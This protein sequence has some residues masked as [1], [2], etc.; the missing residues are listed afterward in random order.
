LS[1]GDA[2]GGRFL[3]IPRLNKYVFF[4]TQVIELKL[5]VSVFDLP[6]I[7]T[8]SMEPIKVYIKPGPSTTGIKIKDLLI[9]SKGNITII[10]IE[11]QES[12]NCQ[13]MHCGYNKASKKIT[14]TKIYE[15]C[16]NVKTG[17][18]ALDNYYLLV[19]GAKTSNSY[20][21][22]AF[23]L[24]KLDKDGKFVNKSVISISAEN[25]LRYNSGL[26]YGSNITSKEITFSISKDGTV[27]AFLLKLP[28]T[29]DWIPYGVG[30]NYYYKSF[31]WIAFNTATLASKTTTLGRYMTSRR[32]NLEPEYVI[33]G[34]SS[35]SLLTYD[36]QKNASSGLSAKELKTVYEN[37]SYDPKEFALYS[38]SLD[39][40]LNLKMEKLIYPQQESIIK[41]P[42]L[43]TSENEYLF[44]N[45]EDTKYTKF[46]VGT[47][48]VQ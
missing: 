37:S 48:K 18:D 30:Y 5:E 16:Q 3:E 34:N 39:N 44:F 32:T 13:I 41:L 6:E 24:I 14:L 8:P 28:V 7:L 20:D 43:K 4:C 1:I 17:A 15:G 46:R 29:F 36:H 31:H 45:S 23:T 25:K 2:T 12:G 42:L 21:A 26:G 22:E 9:D 38:Y 47:L 11:I 35:L 33:E 10:Y 27:G 40:K 19:E